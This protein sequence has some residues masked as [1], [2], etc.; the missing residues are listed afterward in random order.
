MEFLKYSS[1]EGDFAEFGTLYGYTARRFAKLIRQ[2]KMGAHLWLFDSFQG[3]PEITEEADL[4]SYEVSLNKVW[5]RGQMRVVP[6]IPE[7]I[8][9]DLCCLLPRD[10][11]HVVEGYFEDTLRTHMPPGKLAL[12]HID[13]D[14]YSSARYVLDALIQHEKFQDGTVLLMD[15]FNCNRA[16]PAM[17]ERL[18]LAEAFEGH[19]RY[20]YSHWFSYGWHGQCFFVHEQDIPSVEKHLPTDGA[21]SS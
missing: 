2:F 10:C 21:C 3:L 7:L 16:N 11:I 13:C 4:S 18:A 9:R 8:R 20:S 17:G 5:F 14:L 19:G 1:I 12:V 15:D 6:G